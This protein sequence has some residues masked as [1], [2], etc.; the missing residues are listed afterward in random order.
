MRLTSFTDYGARMPMR[1]ARDPGRSFPTVELAIEFGPSR[2]HR[3]KVMQRLA[4][5]GFVTTRRG[6]GSGAR[7]AHPA[8]DIRLGELISFLEDDQPMAECFSAG[9][10]GCSIDARCQRNAHLRCAEA[11]FLADLDHS[12]L[13]DIP[14]CSGA[15]RVKGRKI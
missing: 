11:S 10:G 9:G 14:L 13:A 6:E 4:Q 8:V 15:T 1:I 2:H 5:A 7:L 3:A 12:T